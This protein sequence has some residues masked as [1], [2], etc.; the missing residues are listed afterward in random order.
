VVF[1]AVKDYPRN[2]LESEARFSTEAACREYLFDFAGQRAFAA[3]AAAGERAG[4]SLTVWCDVQGAI[5]R[6]P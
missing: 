1:L 5:T 2:L 6:F 4:R 3:R